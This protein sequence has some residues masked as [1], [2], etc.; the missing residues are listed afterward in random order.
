MMRPVNQ[1]S[2]R[3]IAAKTLFLCLGLVILSSCESSTQVNSA[4]STG[5]PIVA[6]QKAAAPKLEPATTQPVAIFHAFNQRFSDVKKY[7][8]AVGQQGYS[9]IQISPAQKSNPSKDWWARYQPIDYRVIEGLGSEAEL[10]SLIDTAHRCNVRVIADVVFNH[11]AN[12]PQYQ[13][14]K[15]PTFT[16]QDFQPRCNTNY[17]DPNAKWTLHR[18]W[19]GDL[20]DLK[21]DRPNVRQ[22]Q[23]QHMQKLLNLGIDGFRFDAAKHMPQSALQDYIN[24]ANTRPTWNYLE[25]I[26]GGNTRLEEY[27]HIAAVS[28]FRLHNTLRSAF[29][30]GGDLRSLRVPQALNDPRSV[31][32]GRNHDTA[33]DIT[34]T[35]VS[36]FKDQG[37]AHLATAYVLAREAGTPLILSGDNLSVPYIKHGVKFRRILR[38]RAREGKRVKE[39]VL[40]AVNS[41]TVLLL[42]RG[43]EGFFVVNK[44]GQA[45]NIPALDLTLTNLEGCYR[46]LRN[47]FTVAIERRS[48]GKKYLTR[49]GTWKQGGM[50]LQARDALY[51]IRDPWEKCNP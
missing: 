16:P 6:Q 40:A 11:M 41:P 48:N 19:L 7:V 37:D 9:H 13:N 35:P 45:F 14:L 33:P 28:D 3:Q 1:R 2:L 47:N 50:R 38:D 12:M 21:L 29:S 15:F 49:W 51:F 18:C 30:Y 8:C 23:K 4:S 20:P 25:V 42:E 24:L 39:T 27:S 5:V 10:K 31:V 22:I 34:S 46:E 32:F 36:P 43:A 17:D 26:E 44:G